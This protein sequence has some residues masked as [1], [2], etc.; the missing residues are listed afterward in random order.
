MAHL[1][2][3]MGFVLAAIIALLPLFFA[4]AALTTFSQA[5]RLRRRGVSAVGTVTIE[6]CGG[7]KEKVLVRYIVAGRPFE[8][9]ASWSPSWYSTG[10][11]VPVRYLP[12]SPEVA[13]VDRWSEQW[14][15]PLVL[16]GF[17]LLLACC[18]WFGWFGR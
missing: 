18:I 15:P 2:R 1:E 16:G 5:L 6:P 13:R 14:V 17:A 12:D 4:V 11:P 10:E 3:G 7:G 8:T 9:Q